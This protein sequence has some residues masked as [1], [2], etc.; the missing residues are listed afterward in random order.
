MNNAYQSTTRY[1]PA[2]ATVK[3]I[4]S[5]L[6]SMKAPDKQ[7]RKLD[8]PR[9]SMNL[10]PLLFLEAPLPKSSPL[11]AAPAHDFAGFCGGI[12]I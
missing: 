8:P 10:F 3:F 6:R 5:R 7:V 12:G 4:A 11:C 9:R 2:P 1:E